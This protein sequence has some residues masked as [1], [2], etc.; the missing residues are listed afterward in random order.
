M[1]KITAQQQGR[2]S[3]L[4]RKGYNYSDIAEKFGCTRQNI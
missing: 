3:Q 1:G 4:L 2:I